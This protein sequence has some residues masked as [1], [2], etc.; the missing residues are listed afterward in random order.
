M[1]TPGTRT[2]LDDFEEHARIQPES[3]ALI[4]EDGPSF[5][6]RILNDIAT[7]I[8]KEVACAFKHLEEN[9][10]QKSGQLII[11]TPL[12]SLMMNR[13]VG[14]IAAIL[15]ILKAGAGYVPVDPGFP[16]DRQTYIFEQSQCKLLITD[17]QTLKQALAIGVV[18]PPTFVVDV[19]AIMTLASRS[20]EDPSK[21]ISVVPH[22]TFIASSLMLPSFDGCPKDALLGRARAE[23][24]TRDGGGLGCVLYTSGSTGKP[25]GVMVPLRGVSVV[26][27]FF[28]RHLKVS[29]H[30]RVLSLATFCFDISVLEI[31]LPLTHG[32]VLVVCYQS[33]Q[34]DPFRLVDVLKERGVTV[35]QA[36]PTTFEMLFASG[37]TGD[38]DIDFLVG[39]EAFRP[40]LVPL[41]HNCR[42]LRNVYGPTEATIWASS[43][44]VPKNAEVLKN[45][46]GAMVIPIGMPI[47]QFIFM[48]VSVDDKAPRSLVEEGELWIAGPCLARGYLHRPELTEAV[49]VTNPFAPGKAYRTG[50]LVKRVDGN[51]VFM[52]RI[53]D[54]VKTHLNG[55]IT[56]LYCNA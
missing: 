4:L 42:S 27:S 5:T 45:K 16:V 26:T 38:P 32:G 53:D 7:A 34:K 11:D 35:M 51:Y 55:Y 37:W 20:S 56:G 22:A 13:G 21:P 44:T 46:L 15:A 1:A 39:G 33:T 43:F 31:F 29:T 12:V 52:R 10:V 8:A 50:D 28:G 19:D 48:I 23:S 25:K 54:Q 24:R 36:T 47:D 6:Y 49:F 30:S 18:L 41:A 40:S 14:I 17:A 2:V 9:T 3:Q